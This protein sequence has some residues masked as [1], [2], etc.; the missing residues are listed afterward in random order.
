MLYYIKVK[1]AR[2]FLQIKF[3]FLA[4]IFFLMDTSNLGTFFMGNSPKAMLVTLTHAEIVPNK[5][6]IL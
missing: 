5:H 2:K 4:A 6:M 3:C 1:L